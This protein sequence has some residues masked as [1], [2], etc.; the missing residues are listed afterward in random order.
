MPKSINELVKEH[1]KGTPSFSVHFKTLGNK[2][3]AGEFQ[4]TSVDFGK[5]KATQLL[6]NRKIRRL[7]GA[8][9]LDAEGKQAAVLNLQKFLMSGIYEWVTIR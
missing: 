3:C 5:E 8:E 4:A 1:F 9:I 7:E 6:L 2:L